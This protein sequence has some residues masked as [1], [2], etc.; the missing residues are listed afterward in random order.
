MVR[1]PGILVHTRR[2]MNNNISTMDKRLACRTFVKGAEDLPSDISETTNILETKW[3]CI[4][5]GLHM[6]KRVREVQQST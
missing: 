5:D 4:I 2:L 6:R 1:R 3:G